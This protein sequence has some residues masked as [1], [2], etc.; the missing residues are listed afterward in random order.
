LAVSRRAPRG[1]DASLFRLQSGAVFGVAIA[2]VWHAFASF[3]HRDIS[4]SP[5]IVYSFGCSGGRWT[6]CSGG[7]SC[8]PCSHFQASSLGGAPRQPGQR[9]RLLREHP[10]ALLDA[11]KQI[12]GEQGKLEAESAF[13]KSATDLV[14]RQSFFTSPPILGNF[15]DRRICGAIAT[16]SDGQ[17]M[18]K[19]AATALE[20]PQAARGLKL[21]KIVAGQTI[22]N[23]AVVLVAAILAISGFLIWQ[24]YWQTLAQAEAKVQFAADAVSVQTQ[25][26][27]AANLQALYR[28][29]EAL[30]ANPS[31]WPTVAGQTITRSVG[32]LPWPL[33]IVVY[34][35]SGNPQYADRASAMMANIARQDY[36]QVLRGGQ[37]WAISNMF[38]EPAT[39]KPRFAMAVRL[40]D[41]SGIFLGAAVTM[42]DADLMATFWAPLE[43]GPA[44]TVSIVRGDGW[45]VSRYP[46]IKQPLNLGKSD[47]FVKYLST[48]PNGT[49]F[50]DSSPADGVP[51][52]VGFRHVPGLNLIAI[53]S[54]SQSSTIGRFWHD[55]ITFLALLAPIA[56]VL[57]VG[58]WWAARLLNRS[59]QTRLALQKAND[60]NGVLFREIHHRVKNNLQAVSSMVQLH[61]LDEQTKLA[62][63][64]RIAAMSAIHEHIYQSDKFRTVSVKAYLETL[65]EDLK[66]IYSNG[67]DVN[68]RI[69][70]LTVESDS[71]LPLGLIVNEV[72]S[73]SFKHA[74]ADGRSGTISVALERGPD[75]IAVL[76]IIDNG[77]GFNPE[78]QSKGL[79]RRLIAGLVAQ[80]GGQ[81]D[82]RYD[83]GSRF[84]MTF[85]M[86]RGVADR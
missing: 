67:T 13:R 28:V 77:V 15:G 8:W 60:D 69:E 85:P 83:A 35:A 49:Y 63:R 43:L 82:F 45:L 50:S 6:G 18:T 9:R 42:V 73:N 72:V 36:F 62:M 5:A 30:P 58:S 48:N 47:V 19:R 23:F 38:V 52:V 71:A 16:Q 80:M 4:T 66:S 51:R 34:D 27:V 17:Q 84:S 79:G 33:G 39:G 76:T 56:L 40:A 12:V 31:Q 20:N 53:A 68:V 29:V 70:D 26:F 2:D 64:R 14:V 24:G 7:S 11:G 21:K 78:T 86:T 55:V 65:I 54:V 74:F 75:D 10:L 61:P 1:T 44:S 32:T 37:D 3:V 22:M 25:W 81:A 59:E 46:A 57:L 41:K